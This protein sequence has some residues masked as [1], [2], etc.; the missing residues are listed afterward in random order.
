[1]TA[2][3]TSFAPPSRAALERA[4]KLLNSVLSD[5]DGDDVG[6]GRA[7]SDGAAAWKGKGKP[8][9]RVPFGVLEGENGAVLPPAALHAGAR[10][11]RSS[12]STEPAL[13]RPPPSATLLPDRRRLSA[14]DLPSAP[15]TLP[16]L[17][18]QAP[19]STT[20]SSSRQPPLG[21]PAAPTPINAPRPLPLPAH[22]SS[23]PVRRGSPALP[24]SSSRT[25]I[26]LAGASTPLRRMG[27]SLGTAAGAGP[28][29]GTP[30]GLGARAVGTPPA[31]GGALGLAGGR[32][33]KPFATPFKKAVGGPA[34]VVGAGTPVTPAAA[35]LPGPQV[36]STA[37]AFA[38]AGPGGKA[39]S[40]AGTPLRAGVPGD[41][42]RRRSVS[43]AANGG[44]KGGKGG[45][46]T[47][48][49]RVFDLTRAFA[50]PAC[51]PSTPSSPG[52]ELCL[53]PLPPPPTQSRRSGC[54]CARRSSGRSSTARTS[55]CSTA[56]A[57]LQPFNSLGEDHGLTFV[58]LARA[59]PGPTRSP[60]S[61]CQTPRTTF[62][63]PRQR[64]PTRR[65]SP[66]RPT[67]AA[68]TTAAC[69]GA[70]RT[71]RSSSSAARGSGRRRPVS[72]SS[73]RRRPAAG[74]TRRSRRA[75]CGRATTGSSSSGSSRACAGPGRPCSSRSPRQRRRR[76]TSTT[77]RPR[78]RAWSAA[79]ARARAR[80]RSRVP[81]AG[82][83]RASSARTAPAAGRA[84]SDGT[85]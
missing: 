83:A 63:R 74:P 66:S 53:L 1:M 17:L 27:L 69:R 50:R 68:P 67:L 44:A 48:Y 62:S 4:A 49:R 9:T 25:P 21:P 6:F 30:G 78:S 82:G 70:T 79:G 54:P 38:P 81:E 28:R 59:H 33:R 2:R 13:P 51:A 76:R 80:P 35:A 24:A 14:A 16:P 57:S 22:L 10:P 61:T 64:T 75:S 40:V 84:S 56:C 77:A 11:G 52:A 3:G 37:S 15:I 36:P 20:A 85:R 58:L 8:L 18:T 43:S 71:R 46:R 72:P 7:G 5:D 29:A 19:S 55:S 12:L 47:D 65:S 39:I 60:R 26:P 45:P 73:R 34:A 31:L 41:R 42:E 32:G 23:T